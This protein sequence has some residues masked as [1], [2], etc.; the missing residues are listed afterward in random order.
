[1]CC[2]L[3]ISFILKCGCVTVLIKLCLSCA[4]NILTILLI[5][6]NTDFQWMDEEFTKC[7]I[8]MEYYD[9]HTRIPRQ[10]QCKFSPSSVC[11]QRLK[12]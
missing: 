9:K 11:K 10:F 2:D 6:L 3:F 12:L 4:I 5:N 8:C 1:M 7:A